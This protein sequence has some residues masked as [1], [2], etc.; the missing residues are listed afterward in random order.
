MS[1]HPYITGV[2]ANQLWYGVCIQ[3]GFGLLALLSDRLLNV[4]VN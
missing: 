3:D 2:I 1:W 4:F